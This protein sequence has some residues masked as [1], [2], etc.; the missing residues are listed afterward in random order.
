MYI[1][2]LCSCKRP[3][4]ANVRAKLLR[5]SASPCSIVVRR[6]GD[7]TPPCLADRTPTPNVLK[8]Y[9]IF[10]QSAAQNAMRQQHYFAIAGCWRGRPSADTRP[11]MRRPKPLERSYTASPAL[12]PARRSAFHIFNEN[13]DLEASTSRQLRRRRQARG[14]TKTK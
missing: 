6:E 14:T 9:G 5:C 7:F 2:H 3:Q 10:T 13:E 8:G 4:W 11:R 1:S 12:G